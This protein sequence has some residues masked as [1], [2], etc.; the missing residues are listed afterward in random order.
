M[1]SKNF[2]LTKIAQ[3]HPNEKNCELIFLNKQILPNLGIITYDKHIVFYDLVKKTNLYTFTIEILPNYYNRYIQGVINRSNSGDLNYVYNDKTKCHTF[4]ICETVDKNV[5]LT[6]L[7]YNN[8]KFN[9]EKHNLEEMISG[10]KMF[11]KNNHLLIVNYFLQT[12]IKT[13]NLKNKIIVF[14]I[15]NKQIKTNFSDKYLIYPDYNINSHSPIKEKYILLGEENSSKLILYNIETCLE[16]Y[17]FNLD[18][19]LFWSYNDNLY[20]P[21]IEYKNNNDFFKIEYKIPILNGV[22]QSNKTVLIKLEEDKIPEDIVCKVCY[23]VERSKHFI[24]PCRHAQ[25]CKKCLD[26]LKT[27]NNNCPICR[28]TIDGVYEIFN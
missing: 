16:E 27:Q 6:I 13:K 21:S 9:L 19:N 20:T 26:T 18:D 7:T 10:R 12:D 24:W 23:E 15:K 2:I 4:L 5:I 22:S 14:D 28:G 8:N 25:F 3:S 1:T 17:T 11:I